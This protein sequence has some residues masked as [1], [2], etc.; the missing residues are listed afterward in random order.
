MARHIATYMTYVIRCWAEPSSQAT[1]SI[2]RF[3]LDI[4]ATGHRFGFTSS[5]ALIS[6]LE[7]ALS[8]IQE[9]PEDESG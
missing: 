7:L 8:P 6:A 2:Y 1:T 3:T 9:Q 4:P 5:E